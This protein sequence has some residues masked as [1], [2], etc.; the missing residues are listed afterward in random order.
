[1]NFE[2][3]KLIT[4]KY[5]EHDKMKDKTYKYLNHE[6]IFDPIEIIVDRLFDEIYN[7]KALDV[8]YDQVYSGH[9]G[10]YESLYKFMEENKI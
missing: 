2:N 7:D 5:L 1:M 6:E 3:F 8:Y 9:I 4:E 10:D